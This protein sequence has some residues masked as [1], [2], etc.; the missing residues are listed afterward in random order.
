MNTSEMG[1]VLKERVLFIVLAWVY[2]LFS[3]FYWVPI[4]VLAKPD[5]AA[6]I[7]VVYRVRSGQW[8]PRFQPEPH[9][10]WHIDE[11]SQP[12]L[13]YWLAA[14]MSLPTRVNDPHTWI[15]I[16]PFFLHGAPRGNGA[17]AIPLA[18]GGP[19][20]Q[21]LRAFGWLLGV[22]VLAATY[23]AARVWLP[24]LGA[25]WATALLAFL[26]TFAFVQSGVSN[27]S[28]AAVLAPLIYGEVIRGWR[29]GLTP[30]SFK[31]LSALFVL[32]LYTRLDFL[33]LLWPLALLLWVRRS[34]L[35]SLKRSVGLW[36]GVAVL[37]TLPLWLRNVWLYHDPLVRQALALRPHPLSWQVLLTSELLRIYKMALISVGE[38][39]ILAP[40][41]YYWIL[42][43][44]LVVP[45]VGMI[46]GRLL[47]QRKV[48]DLLFLSYIPLL[49]VALVSTRR[50][51]IDTPRY[52]LVL[53]TPLFLLAGWGLMYGFPSRWRSVG[54]MAVVG[55]W[56][57][58]NMATIVHVVTPVYQ[59]QPAPTPL[60]LIARWEGGIRLYQ[61]QLSPG[62]RDVHV[63]LV[64]D[65]VRPLPYNYVI[66]VHAYDSEGHLLAQEDTHPLYG[67]Y[68]TSWWVP[69]QPFRDQHVL[70]LPGLKGVH[71]IVVGLYRWSTGVRLPCIMADHR[72]CLDSAARIYE[73]R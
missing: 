33:F 57:V 52:L 21:A 3:S 16:N 10:L 62:P 24:R 39:F 7:M 59:P 47:T 17:R 14:G 37:L 72:A 58:V 55:V 31:R 54:G 9:P 43:A 66:F 68:P 25:F 44:S 46:R 71:R 18:Q 15:E 48:P 13:Y 70:P 50:Y 65:T 19:F 36:S 8:W 27:A 20:F 61:A 23:R 73:G 1:V 34:R 5:E 30:V 38:G 63:L 42:G 26:P 67:A 41:I 49:I 45:I 69:N 51:Y 4:R 12:P 56:A 64:W 32:A 11:G 60:R 40:D 6:H 35:P 53:G 22:L 28:L 2:L 29:Q